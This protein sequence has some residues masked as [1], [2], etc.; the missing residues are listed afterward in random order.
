MS[1]DHPLIGETDPV[2]KLPRG[3]GL[4]CSGPHA[5]RMAIY[6]IMLI[7]V[8]VMAKPCGDSAGRFLGTFEEADA[9]VKK[10]QPL[11]PGSVRITPDMTDEERMRAIGAAQDAGSR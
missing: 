2:P 1:E 9:G 3:T 8:I 11:P 6:M 4:R 10:A 7:G 5:F